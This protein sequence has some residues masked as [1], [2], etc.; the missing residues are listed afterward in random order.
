MNK[1]MV[2]FIFWISFLVL[3]IWSCFNPSLIAHKWHQ[4]A[5]FPNNVFYGLVMAVI[6]IVNLYITYRKFRK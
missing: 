2:L 3:S 1:Y 6:A 5:H 4:D